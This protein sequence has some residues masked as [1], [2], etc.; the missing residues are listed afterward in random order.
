MMGHKD[1]V[2]VIFNVA[3]S[4]SWNGINT[5]NYRLND[6]YISSLAQENNITTFILP[7]QI[8]TCRIRGPPSKLL[9]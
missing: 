9:R 2:H 1:P 6:S 7:F 8:P 5:K 3:Q 4:R